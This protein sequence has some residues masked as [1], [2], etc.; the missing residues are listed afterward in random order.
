MTTVRKTI[1]QL[2]GQLNNAE[3][4]SDEDVE[5]FRDLHQQVGDAFAVVDAAR[6]KDEAASKPAKPPPP[7]T[8][9]LPKANAEGGR[10]LDGKAPREV[11]I[12]PNGRV[13]RH[14]D[15]KDLDVGMFFRALHDRD[16]FRVPAKRELEWMERNFGQSGGWCES[17]RSLSA[18]KHVPLPFLAEHGPAAKLRAAELA[19]RGVS[20]EQ[21]LET[22]MPLAEQAY[23]DLRDNWNGYSSRRTLTQTATSAG[24][25]T[26]TVVDLARSIMWL[27]EMDSTLEMM[28]VLPG[29]RGQWQGFYGTVNPDEDWV[30]EGVAITETTPTLTRLRKEPT[31]M[32]MHW[33]IS[34]AELEVEDY[35]ISSMIESSCKQV[36]ITKAM[37]AALSGPYVGAAFAEDT[38]AIDGLMGSGITEETFGAALSNL[39]RSDIVDVITTLF[40]NELRMEELCWI[41]SNSAA[42]RL[43]SIPRAPEIA[44][45]IFSDNMVDTGA[46][47]YPAR[48]TVHLGKSGT[49]H[50]MVILERAAAVMLMWGPGFRFN[51]LQVPGETKVRYDLQAQCNFALMNPKRALVLKQG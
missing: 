6:Q 32:G 27:T 20:P 49:D 18:Q 51:E 2:E 44:E 16:A 48:R 35:D 40:A 12:H 31:T 23:R 24:A 9:K 14:D 34:T 3:P 45:Y 19:E 8:R 10:S 7:A 50:P 5:S 37:R 43:Q 26:G 39:S 41:L 33:E 21:H 30:A 36:F 13:P 22:Y 28:T 47:S 4:L 29:L 15:L 1:E 38:E 42:G 25:A 46:E 17:I 11:T